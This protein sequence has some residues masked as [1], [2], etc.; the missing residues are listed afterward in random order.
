MGVKDSRTRSQGRGGRCQAASSPKAAEGVA[1]TVPHGHNDHHIA[2]AIC[3]P[4]GK[5]LRMTT[6][7]DPRESGVPSTKGIL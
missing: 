6:G 4:L 1:V 7:P 3:K 5:S 2:E